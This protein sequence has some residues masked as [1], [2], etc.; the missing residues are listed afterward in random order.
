MQRSITNLALLSQSTPLIELP[1]SSGVV[2]PYDA[3][4]HNNSEHTR[5][6]LVS[7]HVLAIT[8]A[9]VRCCEHITGIARDSDPS[10]AIQEICSRRQWLPCSES[11]VC[12]GHTIY[13]IFFSYSIAHGFT[14]ARW[15]CCIQGQ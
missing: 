14:W 2:L 12:L 11:F 13:L 4:P 7:S 5:C 6:P 1:K 8:I 15:R 10:A 9:E 3:H